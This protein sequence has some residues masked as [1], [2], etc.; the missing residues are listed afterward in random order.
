MPSNFIFF[1]EGNNPPQQQLAPVVSNNLSPHPPPNSQPPKIDS[2]AIE[3]NLKSSLN[4][5]EGFIDML[6]HPQSHT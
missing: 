4:K 1:V 5:I 2:K 6:E 3:S